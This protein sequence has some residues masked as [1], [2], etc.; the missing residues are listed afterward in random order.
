MAAALGA[1][2]SS[3]GAAGGLKGLLGSLGGG[4]PIGTI[5]QLAG[6]VGKMIGAGKQRKQAIQSAKDVKSFFSGQKGALEKGYTGL[7]DQ[8]NKLETFTGDLS[9]FGR[10]E[11]EAEMAKRMA[12]GGQIAG[13]GIM[14][15]QARMSTA[16]A[17]AAA[18]QGSGSGVNLLTAALLGQNQ[19]GSQMRDIDLQVAQQ[20]QQIQ[21]QAQENYLSTLGQTAA[22]KLNTG[23]LEFQSRFAKQNALLGLGQNRLGAEMDLAQN[24]FNAEQTAAASIANATAAIWGGGADV[25]GTI[26]TGMTSLASQNKQME[27]YLKMRGSMGGLV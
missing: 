3:A 9:G 21:N 27:N 10:V 18:R 8:A 20:R 12:S 14:R 26:G 16:N 7:L 15:E 13:E 24:A 17:L 11:S 1:V 6:G 4:N 23:Q 22:A 19:E 2:A 5:L 25:L